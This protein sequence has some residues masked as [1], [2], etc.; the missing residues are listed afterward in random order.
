LWKVTFKPG[1]NTNDSYQFSGGLH[2]V[3]ISVVNA[4]ST[5]VEIWIK[6]DAKE[7]YISFSEGVS[8]ISL[9]KVTFKPGHNTAFERKLCLSLLIENAKRWHP[10]PNRDKIKLIYTSQSSM[11]TI[12]IILNMDSVE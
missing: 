8:S 7:Y 9:W 5:L 1:H 11:Q 4:L 10:I 12:Q 2:G 3:G 6:R